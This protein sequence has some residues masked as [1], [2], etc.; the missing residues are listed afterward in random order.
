MYK[1]HLPEAVGYMA[2]VVGEDLAGNSNINGRLLFENTEAFCAAKA[3]AGL[4]LEDCLSLVLYYVVKLD[5]EK[6]TEIMNKSIDEIVGII[7]KAQRMFLENLVKLRPR[8]TMVSVGE[9]RRSMDSVADS[10]D[11]IQF[12]R[13]TNTVMDYLIKQN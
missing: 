6:I 4:D 8:G 5:L 2:D 7:G 12:E 11:K 10:F 13:I 3:L 1:D 9:I